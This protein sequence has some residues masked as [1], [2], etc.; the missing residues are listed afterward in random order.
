[1]SSVDYSA[2]L[3]RVSRSFSFCIARLESPLKN[4]VG[5]TYLLCRLLDTVEDSS[6]SSLPEQNCA[7][8]QFAQFVES[9]PSR[10]Q[11]ESW[12]A[13]IREATDP[14]RDLLRDAYLIFADLHALDGPIRESIQAML[15]Q[16][17]FGMRTFANRKVDGVLQ[18]WNLD[19]VNRYCFFV[20]GVIGE[21][22][23]KLVSVVEPK[24]ETG[25][26]T[27]R[28]AH[29]FGLFLQKVN[30]LKDEPTDRLQGR[31][32]VPD[33]REVLESA[34]ADEQAAM[35]FIRLIPIEQTGF[36][37]FCAW[38][39]SLGLATLLVLKSRGDT[40]RKLNRSETETLVGEV[41]R[42]IDDPQSLD[43]LIHQLSDMVFYGRMA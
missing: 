30:I 32:F 12:A 23:T 27:I 2:H 40:V 42:R 18:L 17:T 29:S 43:A 16:M 11:V 7:F 20:A 36:R 4:W 31:L 39:L 35:D 8:D 33:A 34:R 6:W 15:R 25:P 22:L 13:S 1:M 24:F 26:T 14:E 38:S 5:L 21:V 9:M 28:L 37:L 3:Q 19:E 41:E 10:E